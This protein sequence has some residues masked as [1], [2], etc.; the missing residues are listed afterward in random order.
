MIIVLTIVC[1]EKNP[2]LMGFSV[3][4]VTLTKEP[5]HLSAQVLS[6][7]FINGKQQ[8]YIIH[9]DDE[10][11]PLDLFFRLEPLQQIL[12]AQAGREFL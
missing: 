2:I 1:Q 8:F 12:Y 9:D 10:D 7:F 5:E 3:P 4:N 6:L 11:S